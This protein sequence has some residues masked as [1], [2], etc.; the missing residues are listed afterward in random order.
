[1]KPYINLLIFVILAIGLYTAY[2]MVTFQKDQPREFVFNEPK[3]PPELLFNDEDTE[4]KSKASIFGL[5]EAQ[6]AL[7]YYRDIQ[8]SIPQQADDTINLVIDR[9]SNSD[10]PLYYLS[11]PNPAMNN[12]RQFHMLN[13]NGNS[14]VDPTKDK[15]K[16]DCSAK[17]P[18]ANIILGTSSSD[19]LECNVARDIT[20]SKLEPDIVFIGGP[21]NDSITDTAG[22]RIV[23]GGTG[24]DKIQLAA[25]RS[26]I[27]LDASWGKDIVTLDCS[28]TAINSNEIPAGFPIPW[29]HKNTNFVVLGR[30]IEPSDIEWVGNIISHKITGDTVTFTDS[31]F[32]VVP[33]VTTS[34]TVAS[35]N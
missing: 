11:L 32:T 7:S 2:G 13:I 6:T 10:L 9:I 20:G 34:T 25:G 33:S 16:L 17:S 18:I 14:S 5:A 3:L 15:M 4:E 12:M 8:K 21:E 30:S 29:L 1:M 27:I 24:D 19:T 31:C 22:N 26:I 35:P 28:G 23:N